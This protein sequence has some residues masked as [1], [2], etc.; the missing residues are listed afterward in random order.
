VVI[1]SV[2]TPTGHIRIERR[3]EKEKKLGMAGKQRNGNEKVYNVKTKTV[4]N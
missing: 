3:N 2:E 1:E 4:K